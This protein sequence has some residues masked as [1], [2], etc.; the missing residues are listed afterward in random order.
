MQPVEVRQDW[1]KWFREK[2]VQS[3]KFQV[4]D[5]AQRALWG[6]AVKS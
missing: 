5:R 1:K 3:L 6:A 2:R 4:I